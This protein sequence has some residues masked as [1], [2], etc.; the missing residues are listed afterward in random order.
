HCSP[1]RVSVD[2]TRG[3]RPDHAPGSVMINRG[4]PLTAGS[5]FTPGATCARNGDGYSPVAARGV[6]P[7]PLTI[8]AIHFLPSP[9]EGEGPGVRG[10][11]LGWWR[12]GPLTLTPLPQGERGTRTGHRTEG[13]SMSGYRTE[14]DSMGPIRVPADRYYG[15]QTA[16][17]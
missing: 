15:A 13:L 4:H 16:R 1:P 8:P 14:T 5:R 10:R 7:Y 6:P 12:R 17:G 9:L 11:L 2:D 3:G